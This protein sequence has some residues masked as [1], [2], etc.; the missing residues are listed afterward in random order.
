MLPSID[1]ETGRNMSMVTLLSKDYEPGNLVR[2]DR[3]P[4]AVSTL[5]KDVHVSVEKR[6]IYKALAESFS[7]DTKGI[8]L[9]RAKQIIQ[10][11]GLGRWKGEEEFET[12]LRENGWSVTYTFEGV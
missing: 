2:M 9:S 11:K 10:E 12:L 4:K 8:N 5:S 7:G 6:P 3:L 1:G